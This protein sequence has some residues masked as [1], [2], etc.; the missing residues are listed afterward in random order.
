MRV[1]IKNW[2]L[3][4]TGKLRYFQAKFN[5]EQIVTEVDDTAQIEYDL[6]ELSMDGR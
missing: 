1:L 4:E 3:K 2:R 6:M 5:D